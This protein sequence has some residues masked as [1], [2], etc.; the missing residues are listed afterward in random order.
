MKNLTQKYFFSKLCSIFIEKSARERIFLFYV[1]GVG[2]EPTTSRLWASR[3]TVA[4]P[5]DIK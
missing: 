2:I 1:A 3:A 4:P 5:R